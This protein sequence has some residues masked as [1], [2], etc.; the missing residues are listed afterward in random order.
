[1]LVNAIEWID[2]R[3]MPER[4]ASTAT[5]VSI[6]YISH[7]L[8]LLHNIRM[9]MGQSELRAIG[10]VEHINQYKLNGFMH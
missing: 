7:S 5:L 2:H 1:M 10:K 4:A 3:H 8:K 9:Y 6:Q